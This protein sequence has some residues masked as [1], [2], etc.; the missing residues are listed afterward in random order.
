MEL[1]EKEEGDEEE[2]G[3]AESESDRE[4][5]LHRAGESSPEAGDWFVEHRDFEIAVAARGFVFSVAVAASVS[6]GEDGTVVVFA[7]S[8]ESS[9]SPSGDFHRFSL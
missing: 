8:S 7:V 3:D 1:K 2:R 9:H 6:R 5:D 4:P